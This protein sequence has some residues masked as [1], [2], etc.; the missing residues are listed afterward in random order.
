MFVL[1][2]TDLN[3]VFGS[4]AREQDEND[5]NNSL[6]DVRDKLETKLNI[7]GEADEN[8]DRE[9]EESKEEEQGSSFH[10]R[11]TL[12]RVGGCLQAAESLI[13][14]LRAGDIDCCEL[15]N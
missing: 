6:E 7:S 10:V 8:K 2:Q 5:F 9:R 14:A 12:L 1:G 11:K 13:N 15:L 3:I 4:S